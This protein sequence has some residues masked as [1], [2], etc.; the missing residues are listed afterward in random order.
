M[1]LLL[2]GCRQATKAPSVEPLVKEKADGNVTVRLIVENPDVTLDEDVILHVEAECPE[3]VN[4]KF[5]LHTVPLLSDFLLVNK[6]R[7]AAV[8]LVQQ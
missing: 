7:T 1:L 8:V 2:A 5:F 6:G 4:Q 3:G